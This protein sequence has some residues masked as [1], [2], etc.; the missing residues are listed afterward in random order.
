M[1][2]IP[3]T[4]EGLRIGLYI[5]LECSWWNHPFA[6]SKFKIVSEKEIKTIKGIGKV[7][8][9]YDPDLSD[10][11]EEDSNKAA[12]DGSEA[13]VLEP[14]EL[15]REREEENLRK[16][17]VQACED[18]MAELQKAS[19]LYQQVIAQTKISM[20]RISDGHAAGIKSADQVVSTL[21][22]SLN[23]P[24][25]SIAMIDIMTSLRSDDDPF[26]VHGLNVCIVSLMVGREY[27]L[28]E[29]DLHALGLAGLLHDLGKQNFPSMYRMKR[30][31]LSKNEQQ[32]W[33]KHPDYGGKMVERFSAI[34]KATVQAVYQHHE[35]L[36]GSGFPLGIQSD[37]ISFFAKIIMAADEY[38]HLCHQAVQSKSLAPA[39]A[40]SYLYDHYI[41][42]KLT[43]VGDKIN[44]LMD[45]PDL[46]SNATGNS[47]KD[48]GNGED[49]SLPTAEL[50]E[51]VVVSMVRALGVYP[52]GSVVELTNG[53]MGLVVGVN[54]E[55]RTKP[56]VMMC[57][58]DLPRN[59]ARVIDLAQDEISIVHSV[60]P[61]NLPQHV[62][63][64]LYSGRSD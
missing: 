22:H 34:P 35:R 45:E 31:G 8:L 63:D 17:Q 38:D 14:T 13:A 39:E 59:E 50:S 33:F 53:F 3:I 49:S 9:F 36:D 30:S 2:F 56:S 11:E 24:D 43:A 46:E 12:Q 37:D 16:A 47:V 55:E 54:S 10:P 62:H 20:K 60:R 28:G 29:D 48:D 64:Y 18:H 5:R 41:V 44:H 25:S 4:V 58:P 1:A 32:E 27:Q 61:Q 23:K 26:L 40:L 21:I 7:K 42:D 57:T 15:D 19:Y 52:P 51:E 6:K